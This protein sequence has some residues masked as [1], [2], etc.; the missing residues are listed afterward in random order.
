MSKSPDL[1]GQTFGKLTVFSKDPTRPNYWRCN[2]ACGG[3]SLSRTDRLRSGE[4]WH[5]GC[6]PRQQP[7]DLTG[8]KYGRLTVLK[9]AP[10]TTK[11]NRWECRCDCGKIV[12]VDMGCLRDGN[13]QSC[14]CL[15]ADIMRGIRTTHGQAPGKNHSGA[16]RS[17]ASMRERVLVPTCKNYQHYG[18]RGITI[19][20][21]WDDFSVFYADMGDRPEGHSIDRIDVNGNYEKSNC[22]W[23]DRITQA[24]NKRKSV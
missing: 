21:A 23:A 15:Q 5:C 19:D 1:L 14:G 8:H 9:L 3:V 13:T 18:G 12:V 22:R 6:V 24:N 20:P 17:W 4:S 11:R 16:Y 7:M 2:C 10:K